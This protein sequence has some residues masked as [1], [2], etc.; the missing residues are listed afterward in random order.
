MGQTAARVIQ[1]CFLPRDTHAL[2][3]LPM[4]SAKV[5]ALAKKEVSRDAA[6]VATLKKKLAASQAQLKKSQ[7]CYRVVMAIKRKPA[8]KRAGKPPAAKKRKKA[9]KKAAPKKKATSKKWTLDE[10]VRLSQCSMI[11]TQ[12]LD[13]KEFYDTLSKNFGNSRTRVAVIRKAKKMDIKP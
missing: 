1:V 10:M 8:T 3:F 13:E 7:E 12:K 2:A 9:P 4:A 11:V 6:D 5:V